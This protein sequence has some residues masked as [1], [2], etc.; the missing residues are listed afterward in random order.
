MS[1]QL[2]DETGPLVGGQRNFSSRTAEDWQRSGIAFWSGLQAAGKAG[3]SFGKAVK[4]QA[5][6]LLPQRVWWVPVEVWLQIR[7]R[8]LGKISNEHCCLSWRRRAGAHLQHPAQVLA[9]CRSGMGRLVGK[10]RWRTVGDL[11]L[12]GR[13]GSPASGTVLASFACVLWE[14]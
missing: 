5:G 13:L 8:W 12:G 14:G 6:W 9:P 7:K 4:L 11:H 3:W 2:E 1:R 10:G